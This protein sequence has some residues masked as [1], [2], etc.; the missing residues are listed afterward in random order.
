MLRPEAQPAGG[1]GMKTVVALVLVS[2]AV[3]AEAGAQDKVFRAGAAAVDVSPTTL[4][5]R[6]NGGFLEA[7]ADAV[8]DRLFARALVLDDGATRLAVVVVDSCMMP[9]DLLDRAKEIARSKTGIAAE[10]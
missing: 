6:V 8:K 2:L 1:N 10:R 5:A 4:P 9:R 3:A 7:R